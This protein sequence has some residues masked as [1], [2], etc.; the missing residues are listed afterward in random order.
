MTPEERAPLFDR[1][2][3]IFDEHAIDGLIE[4]PYLT[5]CFRAARL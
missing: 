1:V 3:Q 2:E 5:E 4:L